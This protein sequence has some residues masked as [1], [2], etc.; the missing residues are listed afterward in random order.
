MFRKTA[1]LLLALLLTALCLPVRADGVKD[2]FDPVGQ[3]FVGVNA[4]YM[5]E[6][7]L[8]SGTEFFTDDDFGE[9][10]ITVLNLWD[11]ACLF[12]RLEL[13]EL[14]RFSEDYADSG[15][16]VVGVSST[17]MGGSYPAAYEY[18]LEYGVT[19]D[20]LIPDDGLKK[21]MFQNATAPHTYFVDANGTVLWYKHGSVTYDELVSVLTRLASMP[22]DADLD[23]GISFADITLMYLSLTGEGA[24]STLGKSNA[25]FN[26]DGEVGFADVSA[27]YIHMI[28]D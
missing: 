11:S 1:A 13:P 23:G 17:R 28:G 7:G 10:R 25:D 27:L 14:Q 15:V 2:D 21:I 5:T 18:L 24:L 20:N 3:T 22:G 12:C 16:R 4:P 19:Y 9:N 26:C 6:G 8:P